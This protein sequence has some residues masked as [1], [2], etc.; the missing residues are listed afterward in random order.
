MSDQTNAPEGWVV[1]AYEELLEW[2]LNPSV[3]GLVGGNPPS[4]DGLLSADGRRFVREQR[5]AEA[6]SE[7]DS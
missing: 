5:R 7:P 2:G 6:G 4:A 3:S 1:P